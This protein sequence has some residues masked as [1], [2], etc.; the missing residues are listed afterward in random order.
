MGIPYY[1]KQVS[2]DF[3]H[4][5]QHQ[6]PEECRR[7]FLDFNCAIH[8][9]SNELKTYLKGHRQIPA[10]YDAFESQLIAQ[11]LR[12]LDFICGHARPQELVYVAIDGIPP[13]AKIV[14]QRKRRYISAFVRQKTLS[15][16]RAEAHREKLGSRLFEVEWLEN[17]WDSNA[18][19]P[20]TA[21]MTKLADAL[22]QHRPGGLHSTCKYI[23]SDSLELGEGE[24]KI[25]N[26]IAST[27]A[28]HGVGVDVIYGLDAD[29]IMLSLFAHARIYLM[30]EPTFYNISSTADGNPR[31]RVP[32]LY[33]NVAKLRECIV[34]SLR[35]HHGLGDSEHLIYMY[36]FT[37][38]LLGN[39]FVP[40][41]SYIKLKEDG[42]T[43]LL[44]NYQ[45]IHQQLGG[46]HILHV[47]S[48]PS[49]VAPRFTINTHFL[50][51]LLEALASGEDH[52]F[53]QVISSYEQQTVPPV[54]AKDTCPVHYAS[55]A[56][57]GSPPNRVR[58]L[59]AWV[60]KKLHFY[61]LLHKPKLNLGPRNNNG[62]RM[63]YYHELFDNLN[64]TVTYDVCV[65]YLDGMVWLIDYY[66]HRECSRGWFYRYNY[67]PTILDLSNHFAGSSN[68]EEAS[69][70]R[71]ADT[72]ADDVTDTALQLL[73]ILP[74][75]SR[76]LLPA[77]YQSIMDDM[78]YG[79]VHMFPH[80]FN[81][82][83]YLKRYLWESHPDLPNS[84]VNC[85][86][87]AMRQSSI[88]TR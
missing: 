70:L 29:L 53:D 3:P 23:V 41:L 20:G 1:F 10:S 21:F 2:D 82:H 76:R 78:T 25:F 36:V 13:R 12:Y 51:K 55:G 84:D 45:K 56:P 38:F 14:Q 15:M 44:M 5:L 83:T 24:H 31:N 54:F 58:D 16:V 59:T 26:H 69:R 60:D 52:S 88:S 30:R 65:N 57:K 62:W 49:S 85:L 72:E 67:S 61:P 73:C 6:L 68:M 32:F 8:F 86:K 77:H 87:N 27:H 63:V 37:C 19:S 71:L 9:C 22:K 80:Q 11:V 47:S 64:D 40:A 75:S 4:T 46:A 81:I 18:I 28:V 74:P 7:L 39:D 79:C 34:T 66:F 35:Q 48:E 33:M 42:L 17:E 43:I 50:G